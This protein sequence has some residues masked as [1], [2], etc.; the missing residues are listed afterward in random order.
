MRIVRRLN[1][2][3]FLESSPRVVT[4]GNFDGVHLGH[5]VILKQLRK[6]A[7]KNACEA[8][9]ILFEP[10]PQEFFNSDRAPARL[11]SLREKLLLIEQQG[12]DIAV[13]LHF[14]KKLA[15]LSAKQF[16]LKLLRDG[17]STK[18]V[19]VGDDF[20][21]GKGREGGFEDLQRMGKE[22]GFEVDRTETCELEGRR[23]SS[24]WVR[25]LLDEGNFAQVKKL[26]DRPYRISGRVR[27][28]NKRGHQ[29]GFPTLNLAVNRLKPA[30]KGVFVSTV[31]MDNARLPSVS[32]IGTRPVF[33]GENILLESH[34]FDFDQDIYG[35][36]LSVEF[37]RKIRSEQK[38]D[39][40]EALIEQIALDVI[41]AREFFA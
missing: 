18:H 13:C 5:Q 34:I 40:S 39:S 10:Q 35:K 38:F 14:D 26:L 12:I 30:L 29:L 15:S 16:V 4:I 17:L 33:D 21:F 6:K 25:Q 27:H 31:I 41:S 37:H 7:D 2:L 8:V 19:I 20:R 24:S 1:H 22:N 28:G 9:A 11:T 36:H 23:I 32:N 3:S